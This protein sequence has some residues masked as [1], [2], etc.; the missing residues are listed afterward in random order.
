MLC[1]VKTTVQPNDESPTKTDR[2][3]QQSQ[4]ETSNLGQ[5]TSAHQPHIQTVLDIVTCNAGQT[6]VQGFEK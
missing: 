2:L 5:V 3:G 1:F 6:R 4:S